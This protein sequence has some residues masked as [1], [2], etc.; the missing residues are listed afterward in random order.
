MSERPFSVAILFAV[1]VIAALF[2]IGFV[3]VPRQW[4]NVTIG[5]H[6]LAVVVCVVNYINEYLGK[7]QL[8]YSK[9][10]KH[11][12]SLNPHFGWVV[13]YSLPAVVYTVLWYWYGKPST[14]Y[15]LIAM[16]TYVGHFIKRVAECLFLH[17]YSKKIEIASVIEIGL[18]YTL[19]AVVQHYWCNV[20]TSPA[21]ATKL[22]QNQTVVV[23]GMTLYVLGELINF[24]HHFILATL[25]P[26][27]SSSGSYV[28]PTGGLFGLVICPHYFG[29]LLAW[30]GMSILCQHSCTYLTW[31]SMVAYLAGRSHQTRLWYMTKFENF[32]QHLK[33]MFPGIY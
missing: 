5:L 27:G 10:T 4:T 29:E 32:P 7:F 26:K 14:P 11:A 24:V 23:T 12:G 3:Q 15:H 13:T 20:F 33:N 16:A 25:R 9:F 2:S 18:F 19:G 30:L 28:I 1:L 8:S 22:A 17:K 21:L 6:L 31:L